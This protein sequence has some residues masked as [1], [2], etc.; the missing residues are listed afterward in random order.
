MCKTHLVPSIGGPLKG[1]YAKLNS[2]TP[3]KLRPQ[4]TPINF[5]QESKASLSLSHSLEV[6]V[7]HGICDI[8]HHSLIISFTVL[9]LLLFNSMQETC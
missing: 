6:F 5:E 2:S 8:L 1:I 9:S 3:S 4:D 7:R